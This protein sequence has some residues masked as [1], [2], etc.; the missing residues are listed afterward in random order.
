MTLARRQDR[1]ARTTRFGFSLAAFNPR[2]PC[3]K[4]GRA[5]LSMTLPT[6]QNA[7]AGLLGGRGGG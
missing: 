3:V 1:E 4:A 2:P 6:K 5:I 7:V